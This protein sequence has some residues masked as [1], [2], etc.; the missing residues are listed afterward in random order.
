MIYISHPIHSVKGEITVPGDKSISHRAI[1]L[2]AISNGITKIQGFLEGYDCWATLRAFQAMGVQIESPSPTQKIIY[3]VGQFGL[4]QPRHVIDCGNSGTTMRLLMGLLA[5]QSF[6]STL[7]GDASLL[8]RPMQRVSIP[9]N[10]MGAEVSTQDGRPPII[11]KGNRKLKGI[12]YHMPQASAQVKSALLLAGLYAEGTVHVTETQVTRDHT[13]RMMAWFESVKHLSEERIFQIPGDL[14]SAAFFIVAATLIPDS[15]LIIRQVGINPTRTGIIDILK[16]MGAR[17]EIKNITHYGKEPVADILVKSSVLNGIDIPLDWVSRSIDEFPIIMVAAATA[18]G[19]T[20]ICG[21]KELR[22]KESDRIE[23]MAQGL[24]QLGIEVT[25]QE[26]G[27]TIQGKRFQ[28]GVVDSF[29]DHRIAMAF[30]I[31]GATATSSVRIKHCDNVATSF[32]GFLEVA[33]SIGLMVTESL[34]SDQRD[35]GSS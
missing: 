23:C 27:M 26:D 16:E 6:D 30:T 22:V 10:Q 35:V 7:T 13:E 3:G 28:G 34:H 12:Y 8:K 20:R 21:A 5:A 4:H 25:T 1:M 17:I 11:I 31:A 15:K 33:N 29:H 32:P 9:L 18:K 24:R 2:S 14:S 19:V